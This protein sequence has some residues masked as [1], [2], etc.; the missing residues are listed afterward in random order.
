MVRYGLEVTLA[1]WGSISLFAKPV[2][3]VYYENKMN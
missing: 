3:I 1:L 2:R